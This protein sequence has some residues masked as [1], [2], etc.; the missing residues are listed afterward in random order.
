[1]FGIEQ[2]PVSLRGFCEQSKHSKG[3]RSNKKT[4]KQ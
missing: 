4:E 2:T 3:L 1:M